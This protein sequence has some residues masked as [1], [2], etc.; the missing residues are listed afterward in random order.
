MVVP[1]HK[2]KVQLIKVTTTITA[3]AAA[4]AAEAKAEAVTEAE[5]CLTKLRG[6]ADFALCVRLSLSVRV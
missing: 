4:A 2:A 5:N 3:A 6:H 1:A